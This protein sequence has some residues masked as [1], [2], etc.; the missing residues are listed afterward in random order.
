MSFIMDPMLEY[1]PHYTRLWFSHGPGC[2]STNSAVFGAENSRGAAGAAIA[3]AAA[4]LAANLQTSRAM[5]SATDEEQNA[6]LTK[7]MQF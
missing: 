1:L 7:E 4:T 2:G 3:Q 6:A 5:Y